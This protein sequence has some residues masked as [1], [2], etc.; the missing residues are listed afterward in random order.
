MDETES[1]VRKATVYQKGILAGYL[2]EI[3]PDIW[4]FAYAPGYEGVPISLSMPVREA[5]YEFDRFPPVLEGVLPE[6][7]QLEALLRKHK[8]DRQDAFG[9]LIIVGADLV[10]SLTIERRPSSHEVPID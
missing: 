1:R 7:V 4:S 5:P 10:G 6:G 2:E 8:I 3:G 9:Q